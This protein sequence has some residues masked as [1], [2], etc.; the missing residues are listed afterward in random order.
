MCS[1]TIA[2]LLTGN[3]CRG[4]TLPP[5]HQPPT[6]GCPSPLLS[7]PCPAPSSRP[8]RGNQGWP[9]LRRRSHTA[10][11]GQGWGPTGVVEAPSPQVRVS[12]CRLRPQPAVF[13]HSGRKINP[14]W[15]SL[16]LGFR[17]KGLPEDPWGGDMP[18]SNSQGQ[19]WWLEAPWAAE[20]HFRVSALGHQCFLPQPCPH[21]QALFP[22]SLG[23]SFQPRDRCLTWAWPCLL[24]PAQ[25]GWLPRV[26]SWELLVWSP[27]SQAWPPS[28]PVVDRA[29][30]PSTPLLPG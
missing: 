13:K 24:C 22:G 7:P 30:W 11:P 12:I 26:A 20:A 17:K 9:C 14:S 1:V 10:R 3:Y 27:P 2:T 16:T 18:A 4:W 23:P 25:S 15:H 19:G 6:P 21:T 28:A 8:R 29:H 5:P